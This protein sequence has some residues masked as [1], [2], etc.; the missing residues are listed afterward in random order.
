MNP[1]I[2]CYLLNVTHDDITQHHQGNSKWFLLGVFHQK[3]KQM[4]A[5]TQNNVLNV[6]QNEIYISNCEKGVNLIKSIK[7]TLAQG[8]K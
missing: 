8:Q 1:C 3:T 5:F 2:M 4:F 6:L 7:N